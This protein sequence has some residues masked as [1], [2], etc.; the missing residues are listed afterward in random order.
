MSVEQKHKDRLSALDAMFFAMEQSNTPMHAG[1]LL[2]FEGATLSHSQLITHVESR[3]HMTPRLRQKL[4]FPPYETGRPIWVDDANFN[5][6]TH[7]RQVELA[8]PGSEKQLHDLTARIS[9][10]K[11]DR[12]KPL[13]EIWLIQGLSSGRFALLCKIHHS[14][15]DGIASIS[16]ST[17]LFDLVPVPRPTRPHD[18]R[19]TPHPEPTKAEMAKESM[20][21]H[22]VQLA[23]VLNSLANAIKHP[24]VAI[25]SAVKK[26]EGLGEVI[27]AFY[28]EPAPDTFLNVDTGPDR[29]LEW[30][31]FELNQFKQIKDAVGCT[32]NDVALTVVAGALAKFF[33]HRGHQTDGLKLRGL[34]PVSIR[35]E[36]EHGQLGNRIAGMRGPLPLYFEDPLQLLQYVREAMADI[37][38]SKQALGAEVMARISDFLPPSLLSLLSN[39]YFSTRL[40]NLLVTN[41]PGPQFP[42]YVNERRVSDFLPIPFLAKHHALAILILSYNEGIYFS[43]LADPGVLPDLHILREDAEQAFAELYEAATGEAAPSFDGD[44]DKKTPKTGTGDNPAST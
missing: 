29:H 36:T 10:Q 13:W 24:K 9:S 25:R 33:R 38:E 2:I 37:K 5:I 3:L 34:V 21:D 4:A 18:H 31:R 26:A 7:I 8:H 6:E 17:V 30:A 44:G 11:L 42:L 27:R 41:I 16:I 40:F 32:V 14:L 39:I 43:F 1:A 28:L 23:S 22:L 19:W 35:A 15:A 12:A 20:R